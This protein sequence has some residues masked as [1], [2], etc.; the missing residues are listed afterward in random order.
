MILSKGPSSLPLYFDS[1]RVTSSCEVIITHILNVTNYQTNSQLILKTHI[2][3]SVRV[4]VKSEQELLSTYE[5][6]KDNCM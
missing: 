1:E 5:R 4:Y 3:V 6:Y 2:A